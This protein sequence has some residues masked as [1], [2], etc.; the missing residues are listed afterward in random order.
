LNRKTYLVFGICYLL[1]AAAAP[2][3]AV[4]L[5]QPDKNGLFDGAKRFFKNGDIITISID[6]STNA[7]HEWKSEREK[8]VSVA[9]TA[10]NPGLGAGT[11]N[12]F[13]RFLPFMGMDYN[14]ELKSEN[15]SDRSTTLRATVAAQVVNVLPNGNLQILARKVIRVNSEEQTIE[16]T[17]NVRP[18]D[19][20]PANV[21]SSRAIAD[22][23]IKVNGTLRH[24]GDERPSILEKVT[25]FIHGL[26]F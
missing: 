6:E 26:F 16:L 4:S 18:A 13:G 7:E 22:A 2:S 14:S 15:T 25:T 21:L 23:T 10:A 17:G 1:F 9:G 3:F 11:K 20:T 19:I 8:D 5:W 12:L 24:S